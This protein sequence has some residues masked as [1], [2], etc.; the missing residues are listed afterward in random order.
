M[1]DDRRHSPWRYVKATFVFLIVSWHLFYFAVRNPLDLWDNDINGWLKKTAEW[2][3]AATEEEV[4]RDETWWA[5]VKSPYRFA[6]ELTYRFANTA[7]CEQRWVMFT[8]PM[9]QR[10]PF[11][12]VRFEFAGGSTVTVPS[13][14]EPA[15]PADFFRFGGWQTRKHEDVI[16]DV[17]DNRGPD[18]PEWPMWVAF[19]RHAV[20]RWRRDNPTDPREITRVVLVKRRIH[21]P[22]WDEP[23]GVYR[24]G[25]TDEL[26]AFDPEGQVER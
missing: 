11:L 9:A 17:P 20:K 23:I 14:N 21:F 13:A 1:P 18:N 6:D 26:A 8:P 15:N 7:G 3:R 4:A 5:K 12:G 2:G 16:M 22:K 10:A 19:V 24:D 25:E